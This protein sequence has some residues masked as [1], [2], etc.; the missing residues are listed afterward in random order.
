MDRGIACARGASVTGTIA[1][2]AKTAAALGRVKATGVTT[3]FSE[4]S[5]QAIEQCI[6]WSSSCSQSAC[7]FFDGDAGAACR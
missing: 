2:G 5:Q 1:T 4:F 7:A 6:P 3:G